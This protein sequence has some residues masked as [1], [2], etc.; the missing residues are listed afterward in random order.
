[1]HETGI[2]TS[3]L[4]LEHNNAFG[5]KMPTIRDTTASAMTESGY[6][7]YDTIEDSIKDLQLYFDAFNYPDTF[8]TATDY[9]KFAKDKGYFEE[10]LKSYTNAVNKHLNTVLP[11]A[12]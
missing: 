1:M 9:I 2:F 10:P 8:E 4:F 3:P 12:Q 6:A 5:M 7:H 11:Y